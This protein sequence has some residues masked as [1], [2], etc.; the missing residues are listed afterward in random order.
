LGIEPTAGPATAARK[1]GIPVIE[2]FFGTHLGRDLSRRR[3]ASLIVANN[4]LAHVPDL[5]DF[6]TGIRELLADDG[7]A[8]FEFPHL[9]NLVAGKQFDTIYHEHYSYL[10]L[11]A[12]RRVLED[13]GLRIFDVEEVPTHGGSL[14]LFAQRTE[15]RRWPSTSAPTEVLEREARAGVCSAAY[16]QGFQAEVDGIK[17][18]FLRFLLA[19]HESGKTVL[20]YGAAAKGNT[21]LNFAGVRSDLVAAVADA[22]P[23]KVGKYLPGSRIPIVEE[24]RLLEVRPDVVLILPWN[25][26]QEVAAQLSYVEAWGGT[27]ATAVPRMEVGF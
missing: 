19:A 14:R 7:V 16:Y 21:L 10:S 8:T 12:A 17:N 25:L 24:R 22:N 15:S 6:V 27:V 2:E 23:A 9:L 26:R 3:R 20:G 4:V 1:Q 13:G 18:E 5:E 11:A